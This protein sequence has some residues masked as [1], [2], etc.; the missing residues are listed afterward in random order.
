MVWEQ[1]EGSTDQIGVLRSFAYNGE[2]LIRKSTGN[3]SGDFSSDE[4]ANEV[5]E[6]GLEV[7]GFLVSPNVP[8]PASFM[9]A[10]DIP[11]IIVNKPDTY[12]DALLWA[13]SNNKVF[14]AGESGTV[15]IYGKYSFFG[16]KSGYLFILNSQN[17]EVEKILYNEE[18]FPTC[19]VIADSLM[20]GYG[21]NNKWTPATVKNYSFAS[22][23]YMYT[24][25]GE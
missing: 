9:V 2:I 11:S 25:F 8:N 23:I 7:N 17:G 20:Y 12:R 24:P 6:K 21:G 13:F 16:T 3:N 10:Y 19:P 15:A 1:K 14:G 18:G 22:K 5:F 4:Q